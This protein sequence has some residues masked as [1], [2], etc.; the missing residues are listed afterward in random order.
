MSNTAAKTASDWIKN[1]DA[2]LVTASNGLSISEGLNLFAND[3]KLKE[4]LGDLVD[5]YHLPNILQALS[6]PYKSK[7]D[8]WRAI[9]RIVEYYGNNYEPS[10]YMND[11][12]KLIND[13]PYYVWTSNIDHH[14]SLSG[15]KNVFEM[16]GNWFEGIC[17]EHPDKHGKFYLGEKLH[18]IYMK[19]QDGTLTE[20]DI[21][22][23]DKCGAELDLNMP[24][25]GFQVDEENLV[26]LQKFIEKYM[27]KKLVVLKLGIGPRSRMIKAPS[28]NIVAS[29]QNSHYITINQGQ[30]MIPDQISDR[31]IGFDSSISMAFNELL[32]GKDL[33]TKTVGP[34]KREKLSPKQVKEQAKALE[35]FYPYFMIDGARY[36]GTPIYMTIDKNHLSYLHTSKAGLGLM[37]DMGDPVIVH[38]FTQEGQYYKIRLGLNKEKDEV[39]SF[40][41][42]PGTFIA[43]ELTPESTGFSVINT[44]I[45]NSNAQTL[46]PKVDTLLRLF[47]DQRDIIKKFSAF[48]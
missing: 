1:A 14:F 7:L 3:K 9:A 30:L 13:K 48:N 47:P 37:Y 8:H 22:V 32:T 16:E 23:C 39:H 40:Y 12:K 42:D 27:D 6:F 46:V 44:E 41:V 4:V 20:D 17:S 43:I 21:P 31:S 11:I 2:I 45:D 28:M 29:G 35:K 24:S 5:K 25:E 33:G 15:F 26:G 18:E 34:V 36:R 38:C 10:D 19:D